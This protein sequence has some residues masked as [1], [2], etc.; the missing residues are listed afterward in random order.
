MLTSEHI[1][2]TP[3]IWQAVADASLYHDGK[4]KVTIYLKDGLVT[5]IEASPVKTIYAEKDYSG[6][7][8]LI[9]QAPRSEQHMRDRRS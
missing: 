7:E 8:K 3:K 5:K 1:E 6:T 2:W 4:G 9:S